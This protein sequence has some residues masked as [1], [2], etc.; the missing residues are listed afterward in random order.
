M[1]LGER[2]EINGLFLRWA[3]GARA[4]GIDERAPCAT[5]TCNCRKTRNAGAP[6]AVCAAPA[7]TLQALWLPPELEARHVRLAFQHTSAAPLDVQVM[8]PE[9]WPTRNAALATLANALPRGRAPRGFVG[10]QSYWTLVGVDGG[11][12]HSAVISEDGALEPHKLGPSLEPFIIDESSRL[13]SWADVSI[14]HALRDGYLPLPQV[15]WSQPGAALSI[16]ACA[17]GTRARAQLIARYTLA[18]T[19]ASRRRLTLALVLRPWQ[20][21]PP[22]QFLNAPGGVSRVQRLAWQGRTLQPRRAAV[23][24]CAD[25]RRRACVA[26]AFDNGDVLVDAAAQQPLRTLVDEQGLAY[27][28]L[29]WTFDLAPG[30]SRSVAV[31]LPLAGDA[32]SAGTR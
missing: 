32:A 12:A 6:C 8:D 20:V 15:R 23:V 21:N 14:D 9:Q 16:E 19:G 24:A 22:A 26:G 3:P 27:A 2:R 7:A 13:V 4:R 25:S 17:D 29:R 18:N 11:G 31:A 1:D 5:S 10:E 30:E 28:A